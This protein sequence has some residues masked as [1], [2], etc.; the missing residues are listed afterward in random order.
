MKERGI[1]AGGAK[2]PRKELTLPVQTSQVFDLEDV[3][4]S[5]GMGRLNQKG[6]GGDIQKDWPGDP[7][8]WI[9]YI[10]K[11]LIRIW[12]GNSPKG[13]SQSVKRVNGRLPHYHT[14]I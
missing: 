6:S 7:G 5:W 13:I 8:D 1:P 14:L 3:E 10:E 9:K 12:W 2:K 11:R 4:F